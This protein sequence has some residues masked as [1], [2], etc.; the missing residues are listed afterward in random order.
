MVYFPVKH[1]WLYNKKEYEKEP[2][3]K[4]TNLVIKNI[5]C[6]SLDPLLYRGSTVLN[7][8][9][10]FFKRWGGPWPPS[11][12]PCAGPEVDIIGA[13]RNNTK[14]REYIRKETCLKQASIKPKEDEN[15]KMQTGKNGSGV[16]KVSRTN[17]RGIKGGN[18]AN[19]KC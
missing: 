16:T 18:R 8:I 12:S 17:V 14:S 7:F 9:Y 13:R 10:L 15:L 11:P 2:R 19:E 6:Q 1:S 3:Y 5:F 4:L